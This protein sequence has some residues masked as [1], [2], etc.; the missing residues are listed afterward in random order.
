MMRTAISAHRTLPRLLRGVTPLLSSADGEPMTGPDGEG[1]LLV[2]E[3]PS[4]DD[5]PVPGAVPLPGA[6]PPFPDV[7]PEPDEVEPGP[8]CVPGWPGD[9]ATARSCAATAWASFWRLADSGR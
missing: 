9:W 8:D 2:A 7:V 6:V 3:G 5:L 1:E 4:A